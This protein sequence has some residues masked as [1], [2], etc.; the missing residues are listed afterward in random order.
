MIPVNCLFCKKEFLVHPYRKTTVKFCG[1]SC[2]G[3][4]RT[5]I[6]NPCWRGGKSKRTD[7]YFYISSKAMMEHRLII[8]NYLGRKLKS[9]EVIHHINGK[10]TDNRIENLMILTQSEHLKL[11]RENGSVKGKDWTGL[12]MSQEIRDKMSESGKL[13]WIKRRQIQL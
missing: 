11:H 13:A 6:K 7:G 4:S 9:Q 8:E 10:K 3:K 5:G 12:K 1:R 2:L